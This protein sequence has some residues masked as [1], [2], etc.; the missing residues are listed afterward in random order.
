MS[1]RGFGGAL[2]CAMICSVLAAPSGAHACTPYTPQSVELTSDRIPSDGLIAGRLKDCKD[3]VAGDV[4]VFVDGTNAEVA[5]VS[6]TAPE[7]LGSLRWFVFRPQQALVVGMKYRVRIASDGNNPWGGLF[8]AVAPEK[9][10]PTVVHD[11]TV[12][13]SGGGPK[14]ACALSDIHLLNPCLPERVFFASTKHSAR[15]VVQV[16]GSQ[17]SQTALRVTWSADGV[18]VGETRFE[19]G[20]KF[21]YAFEGTPSQVCYEVFGQLA[22]STQELRLGGACQA[23]EPG[24]LGL[25]LE[26]SGEMKATLRSCVKPPADYQDAWCAEF[27]AERRAKSCEAVFTKDA[28][29]AALAECGEL[30]SEGDTAGPATADAATAGQSADAAGRS[31]SLAGRSGQ[32]EAAAADPGSAPPMSSASCQAGGPMHSAGHPASWFAVALGVAWR[33]RVVRRAH[34]RR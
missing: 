15:L 25:R 24:K 1:L 31:G 33:A 18:Q 7:P 16:T 2:C 27:A 13:R 5:G 30:G 21:E 34:A 3:C 19:V 8:V 14:I 11:L 23:T 6:E 28:C 17:L 12:E 10:E 26:P 9:V 20:A 29:T 4:R 22:T 32:Q